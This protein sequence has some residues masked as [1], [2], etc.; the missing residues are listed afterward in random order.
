MTQIAKATQTRFHDASELSS[1]LITSVA[2]DSVGYIWIGTEYGLNKFDGNNFTHYFNDD[3][4]ATSLF[5]NIIR[6][7]MVDRKGNLWVVTNQ[8]VQ[9]YNHESDSFVT[10]AYGDHPTMDVNDILETP[11]GEIWTIGP[12]EGIF[13]VNEDSMTA[14]PIEAINSRLKKPKEADNMFLDHKGRLWVGYQNRGLQMIYTHS[15]NTRIYETSDLGGGKRTLGIKEIEGVLY[16]VSYCN[17][18][19]LDEPSLDFQPVITFPQSYSVDKVFTDNNGDI[20]IGTTATGLWRANL[21][22]KTLESVDVGNKGNG[23]SRMEKIYSYLQDKSG[24][25]WIGSYQKGLWFKSFLADAFNYL[26][27]SKIDG[28]NGNVLR[29]IFADGEGHVFVSQ[30]LGG[31]REF[32]TSGKLVH[33]WLKGK[34]VMDMYQ[35]SDGIIWAGTFRDGVYRL[36]PNDGSEEKIVSTSD[37]RI[38]SITQDKQG[39]I[40]AGVFSKGIRS[41]SSDG[42]SE[43]L[44]GKGEIK[45]YNPYINILFADKEGK[46]WIGH[47]YGIDLYDPSVDSLVEIDVEPSL[48]NAIVYAIAQAENGDLYIGSN[49][50]LFIYST[51]GRWERISTKNGLPD[52]MVCGVVITDDN[53]VWV[54]TFRGLARIDS[55][56]ETTRFYLGNGLEDHTYRRGAFAYSSIGDVIMGNLNGITYFNPK[57]ISSNTFDRGLALTG[58]RLGN[59]DVNSETLS[60]GKKI[61]GKPL[62]QTDKIRVSYL[63]NT[64]S[65][66]FSP[67]DFRD[68]KNMYYE[69]RFD[70]EPSDI[71]HRTD[72]GNNEIFLT[73]LAPGKHNLSVRAYDNGVFSP[74]KTIQ[75]DVT[76]PW[77]RSWWAYIVY[78][79]IIVGI[80][81]LLW[82]YYRSKRQTEMNEE[83]IRFFVDISH[84]IRSPLTLIKGPLDK[85]L[86]NKHYDP[87][88]IK[89]LRNMERNTDRLLTLANQI[90]SIRKLEKSQIELRYSETNFGEFVENICKAY[91]LKIDQQNETLTFKNEAPDLMV[92]IDRDH[93]DK[94]VANLLGNAIKYVGEGGNIQVTV[95]RTADGKAQLVVGDNGPGIDEENLKRVFERF[96]QASARPASGMLSYGIGL[97]LAQKLVS[98]HGGEI[99]GRN[100]ETEKGSEFI[101]TL[102]IGKGHL[103][104]DASFVENAVPVSAH[105]NEDKKSI[106]ENKPAEE[107]R[108]RIRKKTTYQ[109]AV[110]DDEEEIRNYLA[111]ELGETYRVLTYPDGQK[112]L[113]GI[114]DNLPD[115]V[116]SDVMMPGMDGLELL[117]RLKEN[118]KTSHIPVILLSNKTEHPARLKGFG[119]GA[120][121]YVDKPFNFEELEARAASL[122]ANRLRVKGKF[123][124]VQEQQENVKK[125][126]LKGNDAALMDKIIKNINQRLD[127]S[128]FNV[129]A[130]ADAVGLSRVQLH[131]RV[132]EL[133]G[134]TVGDFIRNIRLQQAAELLAKG[135]V[136]VSQVCYAVGFANPTHFSSAFKKHFGVSPKDYIMKHKESK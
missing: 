132:K 50:G 11:D 106:E 93:F 77:Y 41:F 63:D 91:E 51:E 109:V 27:L 59:L 107:K 84:E 60:G 1:N 58:I 9:R 122:I 21:D 114:V 87:T 28:D 134:I 17:V 25:E 68:N 90:L 12:N 29:S 130:L 56:G 2:Q 3:T 96:Y 119:Q 45:L 14:S 16:A 65:L 133:T 117:K 37:Q 83:R 98:M 54:S 30:E 19:R 36:N 5:A 131:R 35:D 33:H 31:A 44:L 118:T 55:K 85:L 123:S 34:T 7:L 116:I 4:D 6:K 47:Y 79:I 100:K 42:E 120:D 26:P 73:Q 101:V 48:R 88:T 113:E 78:A 86:K 13:S 129:E 94:V 74:I 18:L 99:I 49:K 110:V 52:D 53:E 10:V 64:F 71:W 105:S 81:V 38:S 23:T 97:N 40:Y 70:N 108:T 24:N 128:D 66:R 15:D 92:W 69:Y 61:L 39:N 127:D 75:I 76:P 20:L 112:A 80:G 46:I 121:A 57:E 136:N 82:L 43:R 125:V 126:E 72:E 22:K 103:P 111:T 115:L 32:D 104:A 62:E 102:P 95:R 8:G 135:D 67:L 124:G 89:A